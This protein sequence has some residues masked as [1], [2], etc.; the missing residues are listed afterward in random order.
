MNPSKLSVVPVAP[1]VIQRGYSPAD[2]ARVIAEVM[3]IAAPKIVKRGTWYTAS[4][5]EISAKSQREM[6]AW[7]LLGDALCVEAV[8]RL[9][10]AN[11]NVKSLW[12]SYWNE[13]YAVIVRENS[14]MESERLLSQ[15]LSSRVPNE[16]SVARLRADADEYRRRASESAA[17]ASA[18]RRRFIASVDG[19]AGLFDLAWAVSLLS[20]QARL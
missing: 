17:S 2:A 8:R 10:R 6:R 4:A 20:A 15:E 18:A 3:E 13:H 7:V 12:N 14:A 16:R 5:G 1:F 11:P 9:K 19:D